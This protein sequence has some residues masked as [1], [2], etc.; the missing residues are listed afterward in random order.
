MRRLI[1]H[2]DIADE[3]TERIVRADSS[4]P[5]GDPFRGDTVVGPLISEP[6]IGT[7]AKALEAAQADSGK[8]PAGG[9]RLLR[10]QAPA[11]AYVHPA[12]V[13]VPAQTA[14]VREDTFAPVPYV[15]TYRALEEAIELHSGSPGD[16]PSR[17]SHGPGGR[18]GGPRRRRL[19]LRH[20]QCLSVL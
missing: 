3:L 7:L 8:L 10:E 19:G 9:D 11:A 1:V 20:R 15:L 18:P 16:C 4:L 12:V 5:A 17:S 2:E 13:R 6:A 14:V